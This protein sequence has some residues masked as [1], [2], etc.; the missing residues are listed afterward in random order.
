ML[1]TI[2]VGNTHKMLGVFKKNELMICWR[3]T[4]SWERSEDELGITIKNLFKHSDLEWKDVTGIAISSVV[5]PLMYSL[6][7][8]SKK[9]FNISPLIIGPGVKT[10]LNILMDD[11]REV[12]ADRVVNAV[13]G[14]SLYGGP[15][16]IVDFGTATTFCVIN[17]KG[18]YQGGAIAPGIGVSTEALFNKAAKLPRVEMVKP[19]HVIGKN[20]VSSMHSGIYYGFVGQVD[21]IVQRIINEMSRKPLVLA[22]GGFAETLAEESETIEKVNHYLTLEGLR[23]IFDRNME[24]EDKFY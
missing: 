2:D 11:P 6:E 16:V 22:T 12:G 13:A 8:M 10:G 14:Y 21:G 5:P 19:R 23:I 1:L 17:E 15:L 9:Y 7:K 18:D 24:E 3:I 20:T 4:T